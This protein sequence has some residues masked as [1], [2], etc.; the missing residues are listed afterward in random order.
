MPLIRLTDQGA[1]SGLCQ[2]GSARLQCHNI[3]KDK[4]TAE[5]KLPSFTIF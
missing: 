4:P 2:D 3:V 5:L 1:C